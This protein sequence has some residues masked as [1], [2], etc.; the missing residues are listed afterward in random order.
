MSIKTLKETYKT[1]STVNSETANRMKLSLI[2]EMTKIEN[3]HTAMHEKDIE[4]LMICREYETDKR[5][6]GYYTRQ[7]NKL[8]KEKEC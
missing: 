3:V 2:K 6:K 8:N 7:I 1:V 5:T 4:Y